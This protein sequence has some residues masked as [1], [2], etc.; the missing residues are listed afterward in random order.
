MQSGY[1]ATKTIFWRVLKWFY[2][3]FTEATTEVA[4][5]DSFAGKSFS[6]FGCSLWM[7]VVDT[8][9]YVVQGR[10]ELFFC[11]SLPCLS[12]FCFLTPW[13]WRLPE[14]FIAQGWAATMS[15]Q[16]PTGGPGVGEPYTVEHN[17]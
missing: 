12:L 7:N 2:D 13:K 3:T 16:G 11:S 6:L 9:I 14:S 10:T 17:G 1:M 8:M 4:R 15:L 5:C